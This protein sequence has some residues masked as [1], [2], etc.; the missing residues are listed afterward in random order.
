VIERPEEQYDVRR[1]IIEGKLARISHLARTDPIRCRLAAAL[2][3]FHVTPNGINE[4]YLIT[5][6]CQPQCIGPS[7]AA[8]IE[9]G[10][11]RG[12]HVSTHDFL[13]LSNS[14]GPGPTPRRASSVVS[15]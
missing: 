7:H 13:V 14:N 4:M 5:E 6:L 1:A 10:R 12:R 2:G 9:H 8:D 15:W 3:L 11:W